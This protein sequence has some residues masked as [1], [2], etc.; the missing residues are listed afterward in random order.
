MAPTNFLA[1]AGRSRP[2][3][4]GCA[5]P[6]PSDQVSS[7]SSGDRRHPYGKLAQ[8]LCLTLGPPYM[9]FIRWLT[10][11]PKGRQV[12]GPYFF[13]GVIFLIPFI[14]QAVGVLPRSTDAGLMIAIIALA[15]LVAGI[16][17]LLPRTQRN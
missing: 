11:T 10:T 8:K 16:V 4:G 9:L 3:R 6:A 15:S 17:E 12:A 14:A 7:V 13:I 2:G 5:R 1:R